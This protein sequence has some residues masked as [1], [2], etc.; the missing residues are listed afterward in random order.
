MKKTL[1]ILAIG[2]VA[3][4]SCDKQKESA[5]V[6]LEN[7]P[8][9]VVDESQPVPVQFGGGILGGVVTKGE[10]LTNTDFAE[11]KYDLLAVKADGTAMPGLEGGRLVSNKTE[12]IHGGDR[13]GKDTLTVNFGTPLFYPYLST[14]DNAFKFYGYRVDGTHQTLTN[15]VVEG[16]DIGQNDIIWASSKPSDDNLAAL[17]VNNGFNARYMR[18]A[19]QHSLDNQGN[20]NETLYYSYLP[21]LGFEHITSQLQFQI[22]AADKR[23]ADTL[24]FY[25]VSVKSI[26]VKNATTK[27]SLAVL[28][29]KLTETQNGSIS[30]EEVNDQLPLYVEVDQ[31]PVGADCGE[32]IF[33]LP[34]E[35]ID[36]DIVINMPDGAPSPTETLSQVAYK[37]RKGDAE[38]DGGFLAGSK[39]ILTIVFQSIEQIRIVTELAPWGD[40][41][42]LD[43]I[44]FE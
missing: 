22:R 28:D 4:A 33:I 11:A 5:V 15:N 1:T 6:N 3:L 23:A 31:L 12:T 18:A 41:V 20:L 7:A 21:H 8:S 34:C 29:G 40:P 32:P 10:A 14:G 44:S 27:A 25:G 30:V 38:L 24:A 35:S 39:Y 42:I 13:D 36:F 9:W 37:P 43:P 19:Y 17:G 16:I 26:T 2:L